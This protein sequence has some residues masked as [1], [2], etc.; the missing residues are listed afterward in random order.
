MSFHCLKDSREVSEKVTSSPPPPLYFQTGNGTSCWGRPAK[1]AAISKSSS[2]AFTGWGRGEAHT[3]RTK[4]II[5]LGDI[6]RCQGQG[7]DL[8]GSVAQEM[9]VS[10][11]H[12]RG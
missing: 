5:V 6:F 1:P 8:T 2:E 11:V 9:G 10:G 3:S 4:S 7:S 12:P